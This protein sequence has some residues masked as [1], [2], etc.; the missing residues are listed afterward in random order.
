MVLNVTTTTTSNAT[1]KET[2][3]KG[4]VAEGRA[5]SFVVAAAGRT[6]LKALDRV[7]VVPFNKM[8]VLCPSKAG[9]TVGRT[10]MDA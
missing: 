3:K 1:T 6:L 10:W 9:R 2:T 5:P 7:D 8:L 4:R